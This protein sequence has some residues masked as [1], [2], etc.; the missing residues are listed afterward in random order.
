VIFTLI[1]CAREQSRLELATKTILNLERLLNEC[2]FPFEVILFDNDSTITSYQRL[3]PKDWRVYVSETNLGYWG[4]LY[5]ILQKIPLE[6]QSN[7]IYII[8]SDIEHVTLKPLNELVV[9]LRNYQEVKSVRTQNFNV[10]LKWLYDKEKRWLPFHNV[11]S[12][13]SLKNAISAEKAKFVKVPEFSGIFISN[14]HSKLPGMHR[15][16]SLKSCFEYLEGLGQFTEKDFFQG[17]YKIAPKIAVLSPGI[18]RTLSTRRNKSFIAGASYLEL[19]SPFSE[20]YIPSRQGLLDRKIIAETS[21][22][23]K[24]ND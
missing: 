14:L 13:I 17:M 21:V 18:F 15:I 19:G 3:V 8:E 22:K 20:L 12:E 6:T 23:R 11:E 24:I 7:L 4:A 5:W 9:F 2:N 16:D 1:I 10:K